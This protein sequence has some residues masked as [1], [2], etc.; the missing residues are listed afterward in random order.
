MKQ[1]K[2]VRTYDDGKGD[3]NL[4]QKAFDEGYEFVRASEYI[5]EATHDGK[6][7]FGYIEYVLAKMVNEDKIADIEALQPRIIDAV[8]GIICDFF[9]PVP[10]DS[11]EPVTLFDTRLLTANKKI[12]NR[13]REVFDAYSR[14][15]KTE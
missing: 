3:V 6:R 13:I 4:L 1:Y 11:G 15:G 2:V 8:H 9:E 12:C 10:D 7:R 5:P 14:G